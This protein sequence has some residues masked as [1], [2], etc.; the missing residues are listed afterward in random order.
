MADTLPRDARLIALM[1]ESSPAIS[2]AQPAVLHQLLE[3]AHRKRIHVRAKWQSSL[4][5][6]RTGYT[7]QVLGDALTYADHAGRSGSV[8]MEDVTLAIQSRVG[9]EF[10]GRVPKEVRC[11]RYRVFIAPLGHNQCVN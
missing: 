3:F 4:T 6:S 11:S 2:D 9:W 7:A 5:D 10:G 1:L 8:Q